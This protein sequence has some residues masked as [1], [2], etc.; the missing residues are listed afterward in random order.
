M[1]YRIRIY[2]NEIGEPISKIIVTPLT[3]TKLL[4]LIALNLGLL[5][6]QCKMYL[7]DTA[8]PRINHGNISDR[9]L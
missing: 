1:I 6:C 9:R 4:L 5:I 2:F 7:N 3:T 8:Y